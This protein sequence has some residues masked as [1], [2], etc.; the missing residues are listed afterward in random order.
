VI[1]ILADII[2]YIAKSVTSPNRLP[3]STSSAAGR[4]DSG[5][6]PRALLIRAA[7]RLEWFTIG[8]MVVEAVVAL[9]AGVT[10]GS[11]SLI[12]FGLDSVIELTSAGVQIWRLNVELRHGRSVAEKA[13][14]TASR[15]GRRTRQSGL[16]RRRRREHHLR[17]AVL[18]RIDRGS[19]A[20]R[21]RRMVGR[22][23]DFASNRG[24]VDQGR[25]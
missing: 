9:A 16:A 24:T 18:C 3:M 13:E 4:P 20:A 8:W 19:G 6:A 23:A 22:R 17:L 11:I 7:F 1:Y 10:A 21:T 5:A 12:A 2:S 15:I 14:R 25:P